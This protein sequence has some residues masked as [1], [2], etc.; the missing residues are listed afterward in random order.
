MAHKAIML[1][2]AS[3]V[4]AALAMS[5][6][7][8]LGAARAAEAKRLAPAEP[9]NVHY[10]NESC[11]LLRSFGQGDESITME[12]TRFAPGD[13][14][15]FIVFGKSLMNLENA[16]SVKVSFGDFPPQ[17][18]T[19]LSFAKDKNGQLALIL[20]G[21]TLRSLPS[22]PM[23]ERRGPISYQVS[24][25]DEAAVKT[26][27]I[28]SR[29][30][31][32]QILETGSLRAA[33]AA[34]RKCNND[35]V[36]SWGIDPELQL[37]SRLIPIG[38]PGNWATFNDFPSTAL[39]DARSGIVN[40]RLLV[41]AAGMPSACFIQ[42]SIGSADFDRITCELLTRRARFS[43]ATDSEGKPVAHYYVNSIRWAV[44]VR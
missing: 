35:V 5:A 36:R 3:G 7:F 6:M 21:M 33:M 4:L 11:K 25:E 34:L 43:P 44:P 15:Q 13:A 24:P 26:I 39:R 42:R 22:L 32:T 37:R 9:W 18:R 2:L 10:E 27:T 19:S 38:N 28:A 40:F 23:A 20:G 8:C 16:H 12:L 31:T 14:F 1:R 41:D 17:E 30:I 29:Q